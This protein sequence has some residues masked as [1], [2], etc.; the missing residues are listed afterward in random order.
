MNPISTTESPALGTNPDIVFGDVDGQ[1]VAL[2]MK[3]GRYLHLNGTGTFIFNV[4][5]ESGPQTLDWVVGRAEEE[6]DVEPTTCRKDVEAFVARCIELDLLRVENVA[7]DS[8]R[9]IR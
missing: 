2:N 8:I 5:R 4:L 3:S 6:Y 1:I 9:H 7:R